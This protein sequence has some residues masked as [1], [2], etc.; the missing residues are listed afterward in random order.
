M[1]NRPELD[2]MVHINLAALG[3]SVTEAAVTRWFKK[4]GDAVAASEPVLEVFT[5]KVDTEIPA[6]VAGTVT[7]VHVEPDET[8]QIGTP[9]ATIAPASLKI[10]PA[11]V[12]E[13]A[14]EAPTPALTLAAPEPPTATPRVPQNPPPSS[15]ASV[16]PRPGG[17][18]HA[19][20]ARLDHVL[21]F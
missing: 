8:V 5:D 9:L 20:G 13:T 21:H 4:I 1:S 11:P 6:P 3:A 15:I 17:G 14:P 19:C 2:P 16:T 12:P 18:P 10:S 7:A